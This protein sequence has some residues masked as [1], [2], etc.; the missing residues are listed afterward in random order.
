MNIPADLKYTKDHEWAKLDGNIITVGIT[1]YAQGELGDVVF[2]ELPQVGD[3]VAKDDPFGTIEAV[4]AV[5]DL[6]CPLE[7]EVVEVNSQ[8]D[9]Q[10]DIVNTDPY[11]KGWMVKI[12]INDS[13]GFDTLMTAET[14]KSHIG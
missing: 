1:D 8:L 9:D 2:I 11:V 14:Y 4:K 6:F 13:A 10:P 5:A 12:K 3:N 7:G